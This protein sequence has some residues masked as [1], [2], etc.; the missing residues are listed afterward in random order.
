MFIVEKF[1]VL[2]IAYFFYIDTKS[3][4]L[5]FLNLDLVRKLLFNYYVFYII[6]LNVNNY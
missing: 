5:N 6:M 1:R 4:T 3:F 2:I